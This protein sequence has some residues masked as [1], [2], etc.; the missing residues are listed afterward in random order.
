MQPL[1]CTDFLLS[2]QNLDLYK[3]IKNFVTKRNYDIIN[4]LY[5]KHEKLLFVYY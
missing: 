1:V 4:K 5:T 3:K 2:V